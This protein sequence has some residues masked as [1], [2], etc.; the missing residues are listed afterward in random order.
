MAREIW[1][2]PCGSCRQVHLEVVAHLLDECGAG[3]MFHED[4]GGVHWQ[5]STSD[6]M[7][8]IGKLQELTILVA[9]KVIVR[10][11]VHH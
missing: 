11:H 1:N 7:L 8:V 9:R 10:V 6:V 5:S 4:Y 2:L 3:G